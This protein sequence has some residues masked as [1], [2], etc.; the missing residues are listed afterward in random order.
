M[1]ALIVV[2]VQ[3]D[4]LPGG[5][6][7]VPDGDAVLPVIKGLLPCYPLVITTGDAHP[8]ETPHFDRWPV[9]CV[10]GTPGAELSPG[11][12]GDYHITKGDGHAD[13]YSAFD[14][15]LLLRVLREHGVHAVDIVG[16]ATDYCVKAT[17]LDAA[18]RFAKV[19]VFADGVRGVAPESTAA[20]VREML[21]AGVEFV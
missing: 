4:F 11:I 21:A 5:A 3:R 12:V 13:G 17:A 19:C 7:A 14:N 20:A 2:D 1:L 15:P 16:L 18:K 9:H 6:L 8:P 10:A